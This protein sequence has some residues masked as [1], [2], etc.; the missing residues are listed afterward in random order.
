MINMK[1]SGFNA[2]YRKEIV[3]SAIKAFDEMIQADEAGTK[4][5]YRDKMWN[6]YKRKQEKQDT[7]LNWY[8]NGGKGLK[9]VENS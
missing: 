6:K 7:K 8:K 4:P 5:L 2:K 3:D 9:T 1:N